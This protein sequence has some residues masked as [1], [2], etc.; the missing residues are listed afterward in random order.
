MSKC[1]LTLQQKFYCQIWPTM[2][3]C[4]SFLVMYVKL[5]KIIKDLTDPSLEELLI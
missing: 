5:L 4:I 3:E 1:V 2:L